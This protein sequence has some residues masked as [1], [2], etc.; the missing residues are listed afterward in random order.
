MREDRT[1]TICPSVFR[2]ERLAKNL[3][4]TTDP[5]AEGSKRPCPVEQ[6]DRGQG[7]VRQADKD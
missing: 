2:F 4:Y 3:P 7:F 5:S 6:S 1:Y